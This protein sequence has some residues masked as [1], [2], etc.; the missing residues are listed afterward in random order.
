MTVFAR[1]L[2]RL[3]AARGLFITLEGP[4]GSGKSTQARRLAQALRRA[5]RRVILINDPGTTALGRRLRQVLLH[6]RRVG[7]SSLAEAVLFFA[8]RVQLVEEVIEP[9]LAKGAV[10]ICDR[11]HDSTMAYQGYGGALD[12][13]WLNG[14]GRELIHG[15]L[16]DV[17]L[18]LDLPVSA[19]FSRLK[20]SRDRMESKQRAFHERVR[21]GYLTLARQEPRRIVVV[22]AR[23]SADAV[24]RRIDALVRARLARLAARRA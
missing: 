4:E 17:T 7:L 8:G 2:I 3:M 5:G 6:T 20:G 21:R 11:F 22:D 12:V 10:V 24:A 14:V 15:C 9:A 13:T 23:Q 1:P 18:L 19:G 16:P